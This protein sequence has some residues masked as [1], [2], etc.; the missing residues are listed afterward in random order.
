MQTIWI[1]KAVR[2]KIGKGNNGEYDLH[3]IFENY[4]GIAFIGDI[5]SA[6]VVTDILYIKIRNN[7]IMFSYYDKS[8][9]NYY[10]R[11]LMHGNN[12]CI[13]NTTEFIDEDKREP[14][15]TGSISVVSIDDVADLSNKYDLIPLYNELVITKNKKRYDKLIPFRDGKL[16]K[17]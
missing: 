6:I 2:H 3:V 11:I 15:F 7:D 10:S 8:D 13:L 5:V 12:I 17:R 14:D 9:D 1:D 4:M 16:V